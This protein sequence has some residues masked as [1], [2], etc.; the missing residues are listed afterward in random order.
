MNTDKLTPRQKL[1]QRLIIGLRSTEVDADFTKM[2]REYKVGNVILF[3]HNCVSRQQLKKLC[4]DIQSLVQAETGVPAFI[5]IDQEG[6]V[7]TR[8]SEDCS[9]F[10]GAMAIAATGDPHNAYTASYIT[11]QELL[12]MGVNFNLIPSLDVNSNPQNPVIGVRSYGDTPRQVERFGLEAI[13]GALDAGVM[14][15]VK[16]FPGHGD[17]AVDSHLGLPQIDKSLAELE[18]MELAPF[19]AAIAAGVPGVMTTHILFPQ[20]EKERL[21]A[22]MSPSIMTGLLRER[23]G[24]TGLLVSDCMEMDAI[25][26]FYGTPQGVAAACRAGVDMVFCSHTDAYAIRAME[27]MEQD[28]ASGAL[29]PAR[30]DESVGR[31]LRAKVEYIRPARQPLDFVGCAEN[32]Q[33]VETMLA[34]SISLVNDAGFMVGSKPFFT[35]CPPFRATGASNKEGGPFTFAGC[36]QETL[37]GSYALCGNNPDQP[38]IERLV[39]TARGCTSVTVGTYQG[40]L[41]PGQMALVRAM[42]VLGV[43]VACVTLRNPYD[44][45][46]L[47]GTVHQLCAYEYTPQVCLHVARVLAGTQKAPGRLAVTLPK[48]GQG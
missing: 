44:L 28:L 10:P 3:K 29:E 27:L 23:M 1:G 42:T 12:A 35:G 31:I 32:R 5:T 33:Q 37:G 46:S 17:T 6:G 24:F 34:A 36:L 14:C 18:A 2:V 41:N 48:E 13:R 22:T 30:H 43:P 20:L 15:C 16:H 4:D 40:H 9:N 25:Q 47:P 8:L 11:G 7:V 38:E 39:E 45:S 26:K 21:P 19:Q